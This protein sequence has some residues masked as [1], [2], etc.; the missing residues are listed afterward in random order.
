MERYMESC[1]KYMYRYMCNMWKN[2]LNI[3]KTI[4][5][6]E[7]SVHTMF[8]HMVIYTLHVTSK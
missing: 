6:N 4:F 8:V 3:C 5:K 1:M 7:I 2:I